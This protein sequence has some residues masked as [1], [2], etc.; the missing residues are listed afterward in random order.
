MTSMIFPDKTPLD[1][2]KGLMLLTCTI[3]LTFLGF[4]YLGLN[5]AEF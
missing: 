4:M 5:V 3:E 2:T 1:S